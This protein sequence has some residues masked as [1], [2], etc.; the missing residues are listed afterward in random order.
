MA[1]LHSS[2]LSY[3]WFFEIVETLSWLTPGRFLGLTRG[4]EFNEGFYHIYKQLIRIFLRPA[5]LNMFYNYKMALLVEG[6]DYKL[7]NIQG[8][9]LFYLYR[10]Y[11]YCI[12]L[13]CP[14]IFYHGR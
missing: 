6:Y 1:Y 10:I 12:I 3:C 4:L 14:D 2:I 9:M 8:K 11:S 5:M 13:R 7:K